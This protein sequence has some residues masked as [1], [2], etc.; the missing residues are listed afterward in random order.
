MRKQCLL[1]PDCDETGNIWPRYE[2]ATLLCEAGYPIRKVAKLLKTTVSD[3]VTMQTM[4]GKK[5]RNEPPFARLM[6]SIRKDIGRPV[7]DS[8]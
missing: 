1:D 4:V 7:R 8:L 6:D 3:V 2:L 5:E